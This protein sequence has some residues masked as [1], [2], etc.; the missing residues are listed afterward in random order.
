MCDLIKENIIK[1][2]YK[3]P[4]FISFYTM[5]IEK[6]KYNQIRIITLDR[7]LEFYELSS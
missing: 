2:H 1:V 6:G 7:L 5:T 3:Q 4:S